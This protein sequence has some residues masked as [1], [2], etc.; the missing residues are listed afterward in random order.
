MRNLLAFNIDQIVIKDESEWHYWVGGDL[1]GK[2]REAEER[3]F[4][5]VVDFVQIY[6]SPPLPT[7]MKSNILRVRSSLDGIIQAVYPD[8]LFGE[9]IDFVGLN[10]RIWLPQYNF[11]RNYYLGYPG[12][13]GS[14]PR[15]FHA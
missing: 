15:G 11:K 12:N 13:R 1:L 7:L 8:H 6:P 14:W 2:I 3:N 10:L 4:Y 5:Y 9:F